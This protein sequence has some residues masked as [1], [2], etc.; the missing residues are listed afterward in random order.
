VLR[1]GVI[2]FA[3]LIGGCVFVVLFS[4]SEWLIISFA[5]LAGMGFCQYV[6]R[7]ANGILV[8][9]IV[10]DD[11]RGRVTSLYQLEHGLAPLATLIISLMVHLWDPADAVTTVGVVALCGAVLMALTF[12]AARRLE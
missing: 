12:R 1:K 2:S 8:Q 5:L 3:G 10:T 11:M 6:F 7:V 9:T 4:R